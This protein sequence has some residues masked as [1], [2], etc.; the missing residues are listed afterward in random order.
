MTSPRDA[1]INNTA[2]QRKVRMG[3]NFLKEGRVRSRVSSPGGEM[4]LS[5]GNGLIDTLKC[6]CVF[7][8]VVAEDL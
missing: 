7:V 5:S 4:K 6:W 3:S 1:T 2:L 8:Y